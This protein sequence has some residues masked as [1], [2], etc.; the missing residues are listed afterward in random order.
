MRLKQLMEDLV[1]AASRI[2]SGNVILQ[3]DDIDL[4]ELVRQTGGEFNEKL[5]Q[6]G[7]NVI[8]K[9]QKEAVMIYADGRQLWRVIGNLYNNTSKY[10]MRIPACM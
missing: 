8:S 2:S 1:D 7:L 5:E 10:A 4:V 6:K 9:F 3:M